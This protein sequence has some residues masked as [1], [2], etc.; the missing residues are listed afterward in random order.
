MDL[1]IDGQEVYV[2]TLSCQL[3]V[4]YAIN[5]P[6]GNLDAIAFCVGMQIYTTIVI[7]FSISIFSKCFLGCVNII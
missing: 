5:G 2:I 3:C 1:E 6:L 4:S 7:I